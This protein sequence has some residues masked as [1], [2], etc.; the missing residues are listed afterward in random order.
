M[1]LSK[2]TVFEIA[3]KDVVIREV[4]VTMAR[5]ILQPDPDADFL[6]TALFKDVRLNDLVLLTSLTRDEIEEMYP[7]DLRKIIEASKAKNPDFFEML[8]RVLLP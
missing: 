3:G 8:D 7:S 6:N 2:S 4:T 5:Q 1:S